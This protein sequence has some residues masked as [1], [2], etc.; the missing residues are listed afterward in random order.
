MIVLYKNFIKDIV[1]LLGVPTIDALT[2]G[3]QMFHYEQRISEIKSNDDKA[4]QNY[5]RITIGDLGQIM[6][7]VIL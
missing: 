7:Q 1:Q 3:A 2:F 6:L 4:Q 5:T